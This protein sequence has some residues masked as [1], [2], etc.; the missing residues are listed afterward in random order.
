MGK[1]T[2]IKNKEVTNDNL[3]NVTTE[4]MTMPCNIEAEK[5]VLGAFLNNNENINKVGD[6]LRPDHFYIPLH[7]KIFETIQRFYERGLISSPVTLKNYF[8]EDES[9][10][11]LNI[12]SLDYLLKLSV[13]SA[14]VINLVSYAKEI[15]ETSLRRNLIGIGEDVVVTAHEHKA[16]ISASDLIESAEQKLFHLAS[17]GSSDIPEGGYSF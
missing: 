12:S 6:F 4:D 16:E 17:D 13:N 1:I 15:Y 3:Q 14:S 9:I 5:A 11:E 10:K 7:G 2:A 8:D